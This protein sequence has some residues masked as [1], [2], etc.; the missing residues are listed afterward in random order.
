MRFAA[1]L[2]AFVLWNAQVGE[3]II[4]IRM[5]DKTGRTEILLLTE[6]GLRWDRIA[7][8]KSADVLHGKTDPNSPLGIPEPQN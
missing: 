5:E 7:E 4:T 6:D 3:Q 2:L 8:V 1:G